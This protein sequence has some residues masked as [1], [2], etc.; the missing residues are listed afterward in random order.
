MK[1]LGASFVHRGNTWCELLQLNSDSE[2]TLVSP[3]SDP[4]GAEGHGR[5]AVRGGREASGQVRDE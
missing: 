5:E 1:Q 4:G 3:L 2:N